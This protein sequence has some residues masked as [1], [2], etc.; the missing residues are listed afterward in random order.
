[1]T[2]MW[3]GEI[4]ETAAAWRF[5]RL[6]NKIA[7]PLCTDTTR[8]IK[9]RQLWLGFH[10]GGQVK[11]W[12]GSRVPPCGSTAGMTDGCPAP[13]CRL[14]GLMWLML[15][16]KEHMVFGFHLLN[17]CSL[18]AIDLEALV[19]GGGML[20]VCCV[21]VSMRIFVCVFRREVASHLFFN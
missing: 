8:R 3:S 6:V 4:T 18:A 19:T 14:P 7:C 21:C 13:P 9:L 11:P 17:R 16:W 12:P 10:Q 2:G 1:M 5:N 15:E 20:W